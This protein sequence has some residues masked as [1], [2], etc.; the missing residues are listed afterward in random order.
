MQKALWYEAILLV[1]RGITDLVRS[2]T[3][4]TRSQLGSEPDAFD[5][6]LTLFELHRALLN[7]C[8]C[9]NVSG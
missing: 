8:F 1:N 3:T 6:K 7:S 2:P 9:N 5:E 4:Q